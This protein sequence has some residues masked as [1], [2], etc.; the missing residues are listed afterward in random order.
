M[1][2]N[3]VSIQRTG[4]I[5]NP[6]DRQDV[7]LTYELL[8]EIWSLPEAPADSSTGFKANRFALSI[9][10]SLFQHL[11]LPY[12]CIDLSLS[13]QL[14]HLS[15]AAHTLM[16]LWSYESTAT[17]LMP[18]QLYVDIIIMVKNVYFCVAKAKVDEPEGNFWIILLGTDHLKVL[19]GILRTMIGNDANLNVLQLGQ[20]LTGTTEVS[21]ILAQYPHWDRAPRLLHLPALTKDGLAIDKGVDHIGPSSWRGDVQVSKVVLQTSWKMGRQEAEKAFLLLAPVLKE[22]NQRGRDMFSPLGK[23]LVK[24]PCDA[25]DVDD[26]F[27]EVSASISDSPDVPGLGAELEDALAEEEASETHRHK[28]YFELDRKQVSKARYLS[29]AFTAFKRVGSTDRLK[30]VTRGT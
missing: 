2:H 1:H 5:L 11:L 26:T 29:Q 21:T 28:P 22:I 27:D 18:T 10:R 9:L 14:T 25:D 7:C 4:Y 20:C 8:R 24:A 17:K 6:N 19:S 3:G 13:E 12:I 30:R 23:G 15:A 16:A